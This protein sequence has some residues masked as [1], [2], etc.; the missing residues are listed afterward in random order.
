[1]NKHT[2][3]HTTF[4]ALFAAVLLIASC[5]Y[6]SAQVVLSNPLV[7]YT[8]DVPNP[9]VPNDPTVPVAGNVST[10]SFFPADFEASVTSSSGLAVA[11]TSGL[12][13][14]LMEANPGLYFDV[15]I[16]LTLSAA[17]NY[18]LVAP[19]SGSYAG[20]TLNAV[21]FTLSVTEVDE[22]PYALS[23]PQYTAVIAVSPTVASVN[24]PGGFQSGTFAGSI[25]LDINTIK[26]HFGLGAGQNI[27]GMRLQISPSLT[28]WAN[29]GSAN[30]DLRNFDVS[31]SVVPEPSTFALLVLGGI[32][33]GL[34]LKRRRRP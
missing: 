29:G 17:A 27:T 3:F 31:K 28:V 13:G 34:A 10:I 19:I 33:G 26:V 4:N 21:P 9:L 2:D 12:V 5:A 7:T 32:A 20:A 1:M 25:T 23:V 18:N 16:T 11:S 22:S 15:P 30:A 24:G 14:L 8:Y 6:S